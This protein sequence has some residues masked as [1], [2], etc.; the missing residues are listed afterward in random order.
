MGPA[1]LDALFAASPP[2]AIVGGFG[3]FS[4][5]WN[6]PMDAA[7]IDYARRSGFVRV[8]DDWTIN[9]LPKRTGLGT[10]NHA[11]IAVDVATPRRAS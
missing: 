2:A 11:L 7:L 9:G 1:T 5:K 3:P 10:T 8:A 6:P 4:F